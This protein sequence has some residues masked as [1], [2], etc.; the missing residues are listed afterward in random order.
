MKTATGGRSALCFTIGLLLCCAGP[1]H[2]APAALDT[3]FQQDSI[4]RVG[5]SPLAASRDWGNPKPATAQEVVADDLTEA[6]RAA[7][8]GTPR[9]PVA[10]AANDDPSPRPAAAAIGGDHSLWDE[11]SLIGKIFIALGTLLTVASAARMF[12][13]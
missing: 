13:A 6:D 8:D 12:M 4:A 9:P 3:P 2:A 10:V 5:G 11:T 1:L 7:Q